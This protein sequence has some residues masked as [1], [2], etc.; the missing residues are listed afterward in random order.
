MMDE[1][2]KASGH[3]HPIDAAMAV[4]VDHY[5]PDDLLV[6]VDIA[7]M[8]FGLEARSPLLDHKLCEFA[9]R[10]PTR[11][12]IRRGR[13][14]YLLRR[15]VADLV[16]PSV[17]T[18]PKKGF[19]VPLDRWFR[20]EL[21]SKARDLLGSPRSLTRRYFQAEQVNQIL[22]EHAT[23]RAAHGHRLWALIMLELWNETR[24]ETRPRAAI[25]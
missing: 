8:A 21:G 18:G 23:G 15:A 2:F 17:L 19:G 20:G 5:L 7:S 16:P 13:T 1:A 10:L 22:H 25:E 4:D 9:A 3:L 11:L 14:K 6:K 12:K 24:L